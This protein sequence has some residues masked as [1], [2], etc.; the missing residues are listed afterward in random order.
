MLLGMILVIS[1]SAQTSFR[2][3]QHVKSTQP[4]QTMAANT[5]L[6]TD[7]YTDS[8]VPGKVLVFL[9]WSQSS[10]NFYALIFVK[11]TL[12]EFVSQVA[13]RIMIMASYVVNDK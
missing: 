6:S 12:I 3:L 11:N 8:V 2:G 5:M 10:L 1:A 9:P 4:C 7:R 13:Y